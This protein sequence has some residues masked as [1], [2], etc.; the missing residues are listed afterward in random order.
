MIKVLVVRRYDLGRLQRNKTI[1]NIVFGDIIHRYAIDV[2]GADMIIFIDD[3]GT[4]KSLKNRYGEEYP[5]IPN[6][7]IGDIVEPININGYLRSGASVYDDAVIVSVDPFVLVSRETD[8]MWSQMEKKNFRFKEK[9][10]PVMLRD[11][12]RRVIVK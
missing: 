5:I 2:R 1:E 11:C 3:D 6:L 9:A 7:Q 10:T 4:S 12:L 8:M